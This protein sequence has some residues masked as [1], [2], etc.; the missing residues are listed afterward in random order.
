MTH[1]RYA[2]DTLGTVLSWAEEAA[3]RGYDLGLFFTDSKGGTEHAKQVCAGCPVRERCLSEAL[4]AEAGYRYGIYGGLTPTERHALAAGRTPN[5][6]RTLQTIW[7]ER[8]QPHDGGHTL[9][10]GAVPVRYRGR[11]RTP[12]QLA[13]ELDRDRLPVGHVQRTCEVDGCVLPAHLT[14][15]T[16][17]DQRAADQPPAAYSANGRPFA[18]CG[19]RSAYQRHVKNKEPIDA[20]CRQANTDA[21]N[22]LVRTGTTKVLA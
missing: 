9:W 13:F 3:C 22:R 4:R 14:D 1:S 19:T 12:G 20:A 6:E 7:D 16:E 11:N 2:P 8:A 18:R 15:Q 5:P 17:R 21:H 10:T